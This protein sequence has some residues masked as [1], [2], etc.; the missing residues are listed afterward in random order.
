MVLICGTLEWSQNHTCAVAAV[1]V[2]RRPS[3]VPTP[4]SRRGGLEDFDMATVCASSLSQIGCLLY[5][6]LVVVLAIAVLRCLFVMQPT[7]RVLPL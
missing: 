1:C 2:P 3:P 7:L 4:R 5:V 6:K